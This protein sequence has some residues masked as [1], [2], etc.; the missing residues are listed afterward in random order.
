MILRRSRGY[1]PKPIRVSSP[2]RARILGTGAELKN[3]VCLYKGQNAFL[4]QHIGDLENYETLAYFQETV[5]HLER[6]LE[7]QP[8][9]V[10]FDLHPGYL[11]TQYALSR[12]GLEKMPIQHHHAHL[13]SA[14]AEH[15]LEGDCLGIVCDGTGY[16]TDGKI[17]G[18]EFLVG[19]YL[20]FHRFGHLKYIPLPGGQVSIKKPYRMALSYLYAIFGESL[21]EL[22]LCQRLPGEEVR[23]VKRL[24]ESGFNSPMVSSMGRLFDAV[25][26]LLQIRDEVTF[27]G[28]AALELEMA[29]EEG[30][31]GHYEYG[32]ER[33]PEGTIID[34]IPLISG[35]IEGLQ[36]G[37]S[38]ARIATSF[39]NTVALFLLEVAEQMT[40]E[41]GLNRVILSGG[42]FQNVYLLERLRKGLMEAGLT[43]IVHQRV[44][45]N[46]GGIALGQVAIA[47][48]RL[49]RP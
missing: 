31:E 5:H 3:T 12:E 24:L 13:C 15:Q 37:V 21:D 27:E 16:G 33:G 18:C 46:D 41:T 22:S 20:D 39:H 30:W 14:M 40:K 8:E 26:S 4:S 17:W 19:G 34:P 32:L 45:A 43:P 6:I 7:I 25:S 29:V 1:A 9:A 47:N 44:P 35:I 42:V 49:A 11:S 2:A 38:A 10:A 36:A 23:V 48:A 28:Q